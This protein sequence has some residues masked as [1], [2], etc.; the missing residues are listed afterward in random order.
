MVSCLYVTM[1]YRII[2]SWW[3]AAYVLLWPPESLV[4]W[5][6]FWNLYFKVMHVQMLPAPILQL[7]FPYKQSFYYYL[8]TQVHS[9][10]SKRTSFTKSF[11]RR[12]CWWFG[13]GEERRIYIFYFSVNI[14]KVLMRHCPLPSHFSI[15]C[16]WQFPFP[17]PYPSQS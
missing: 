17:D 2:A 10:I 16:Y 5:F 1:T 6:Y 9:S 13:K 11:L 15:D 14:A 4:L 8:S 12:C 7:I 3:L